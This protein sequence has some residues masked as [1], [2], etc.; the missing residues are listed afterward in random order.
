MN[1]SRQENG[2]GIT[3]DSS[4]QLSELRS[5]IRSV[6]SISGIDKRFILVELQE[7]SG[8]VLF[9]RRTTW[10]PILELMQSY[11]SAT[12]SNESTTHNP[13]PDSEIKQM[14]VMA[15]K[16]PRVGMA[17]VLSSAVLMHRTLLQLPVFTM[18]SNQFSWTYIYLS[19]VSKKYRGL[20]R[21]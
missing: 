3:D 1:S 14:I 2:W 8:S 16:G 9:R 20:L 10:S 13:F 6:A 17:G 5:T 18:S 7:S 21:L 11:G 15:L 12:C 4:T 19:V